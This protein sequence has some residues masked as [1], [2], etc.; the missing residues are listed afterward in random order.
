MGLLQ[1]VASLGAVASQQ[2]A[3]VPLSF[4]PRGASAEYVVNGYFE[5]FLQRLLLR[6]VQFRDGNSFRRGMGR[7]GLA[8]RAVLFVRLGGYHRFAALEGLEIKGHL[9]AT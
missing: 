1:D 9:F 2:F 7:L 5:Q 4:L 8:G 3:Q 6:I